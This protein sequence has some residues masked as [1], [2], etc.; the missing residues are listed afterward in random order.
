V[1]GYIVFSHYF[2]SCSRVD[3]IVTDVSA[4]AWDEN[5]I[6]QQWELSVKC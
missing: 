1:L 5:V 6:K 4:C 3:L 2:S